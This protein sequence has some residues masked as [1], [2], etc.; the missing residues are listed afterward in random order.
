MGIAP[1]KIAASLAGVVAQRLVRTI[2]PNCKA[3]HYPSKEVLAMLRYTGDHRRQ[4]HRG[5][6]CQQCF[7][8]GCRGRTGIYEF[9]RA[10]PEIKDMITA[11]ASL[12]ELQKQHKL[13]GGTTLLE[14]GLRRAEDG[15]TSVEEVMRV[16]FFD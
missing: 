14:D 5:S 1:F 12:S 7:D 11:G 13:Q 6:G 8:T 16:A 3:P 9:L 2:C 10:T 4:F 15:A